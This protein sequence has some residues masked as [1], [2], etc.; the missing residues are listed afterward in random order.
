MELREGSCLCHHQSKVSVALTAISPTCSGKSCSENLGGITASHVAACKLHAFG[1]VSGDLP[2]I[3]INP[4]AGSSSSFLI[5][6]GQG[7]YNN[8]ESAT[9]LLPSQRLKTSLLTNSCKKITNQ[10]FETETTC[11]IAQAFQ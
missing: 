11:L 7:G 10:F 8:D 3:T 5:S 6:R 9:I 4:E 1:Q 2:R